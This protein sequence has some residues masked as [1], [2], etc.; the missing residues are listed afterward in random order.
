MAGSPRAPLALALAV[1]ATLWPLAGLAET[2][3]TPPASAP[4]ARVTAPR[5]DA[6]PYRTMARYGFRSTFPGVYS[7]LAPRGA[8]VDRMVTDVDQAPGTV[9][10]GRPI[11]GLDRAAPVI[12]VPELTAQ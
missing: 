6:T 5:D 1:A 3:A 11:E 4:A 10:G 7:A 9:L 2:G 8:H 12:P